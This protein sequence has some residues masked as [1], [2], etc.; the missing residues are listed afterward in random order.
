[1]NNKS[2]DKKYGVALLRTCGT[3]KAVSLLFACF[4]HVHNAQQALIIGSENI[5][6]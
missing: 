2:D 1:M 5:P 3:Q 6:L 4:A